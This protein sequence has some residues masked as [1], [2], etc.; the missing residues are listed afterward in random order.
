MLLIEYP[1]Y[2]ISSKNQNATSSNTLEYPQKTE[3]ARP[4]TY[5]LC[6]LS[7]CLREKERTIWKNIKMWMQTS[8]SSIPFLTIPVRWLLTHQAKM[9]LLADFLAASTP[10]SSV[11]FPFGRQAKL[12]QMSSTFVEWMRMGWSLSI[13][14]IYSEND[15]FKITRPFQLTPTAIYRYPSVV[16]TSGQT[17]RPFVPCHI[18]YQILNQ[19]T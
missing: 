19:I 10:S 18:C 2:T 4:I 15:K 8:Y 16:W 7:F 11:D 12:Q 9:K 17:F 13:D 1:P 6:L 3:S 14:Q 5:L